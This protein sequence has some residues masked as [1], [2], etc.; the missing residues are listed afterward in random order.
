MLGT[1]GDRLARYGLIIAA[2]GLIA[3]LILAPMHTGGWQRLAHAYLVNLGFFLTVA[4]GGLAFVLFAYLFRAGWSV[5]VRRVPEVL[6]TTTGI[7]GLLFV[8]LLIT[9]LLQTG[10]LYDWAV[11]VDDAGYDNHAA[12]PIEP[13]P[14]PDFDIV[15]VADPAEGQAAHDAHDHDHDHDHD[16]NH[17][18][19][20]AHDAA[21]SADAH[22]DTHAAGHADGHGASNAPSYLAKKKS[23]YLNPW[24]FTLRVV[25]FFGLWFWMA[26]WFWNRSVEQDQTGDGSLTLRMQVR[27]P[28]KV[29]LFAMVTTFG[30]FDIFMSLSPDWYSTMFGVYMFAGSM[31]SCLCVMVLVYR[32]LQ[33]AGF[34]PTSIT[35]EHYHDLGKLMFAFV[36][37]WGY[38]AFSQYMLYAYASVPEEVFWFADRGASAVDNQYNGWT[39]V[40]LSLLFGH[41][42]I[43]FVGLL[44]RHVK[45]NP[46][47]LQFWAVW[48]LVFHW[49]DVYWIV[50]PQLSADNMVIDAAIDPATGERSVLLL[51]GLIEITTFIAVA[52]VVLWSVAGRLGRHS[53]IPAK[54]PRLK[55]SLGFENL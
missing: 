5:V 15:P 33:R 29:L 26:S 9:V 14:G 50:M 6:G 39:W 40:S 4:V 38:V 19:D 43:P 8:P 23:G 2:V 25:V 24:F 17:D 41:F 47:G 44:S 7:L 13:Q 30:F 1:R 18:H 49:I 51:F 22:G 27:A 36:F 52:G 28:F 34:V 3:S 20:H 11:H 37:F 42:L 45:R 53:L 35:T 10:T 48:L 32:A 46:L 54:D 21:H 55:E 12:A 16:H 31:L